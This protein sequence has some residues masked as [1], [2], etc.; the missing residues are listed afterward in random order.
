MGW[1]FG[2]SVGDDVVIESGPQRG[3]G[4]RVVATTTETFFGGRELVVRIPGLLWDRDVVVNE[5]DTRNC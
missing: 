2:A 3:Q 4:G 5:H 1:F